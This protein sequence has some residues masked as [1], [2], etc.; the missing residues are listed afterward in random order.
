MTGQGTKKGDTDFVWHKPMACG[1][2]IGLHDL[3][4]ANTIRLLRLFRL[5]SIILV[6]WRSLLYLW[7]LCMMWSGVVDPGN[8]NSK[9]FPRLPTMVLV[10]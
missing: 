5:P 1:R 2:R 7:G 4:Y 6:A 10:E 8:P 9:K 3:L